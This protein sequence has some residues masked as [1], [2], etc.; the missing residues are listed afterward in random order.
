MSEHKAKLP[1]EAIRHAVAEALNE[2]VGEGDI[3]AALLPATM[4]ARAHVI[5]RQ[6][7]VLCGA[8]WFDEVYAQLDT[9][10]EV[11]WQARDGERVASDQLLC[12]L[13]GPARAILT[14]ER[15]ALNFLQLLSGTAT[16]AARFSA[17]VTGTGA[18]ILDTRKTLPGLRAAQ[19]YATRCGGC[20]NHRM[21][22][23]DG[24]LIKENH[25]AV[26]GGIAPAIVEA[27]RQR[28][29]LSIEV[30]VE[31]LTQLEEA[32]AAGA[33]IA[34]LDNFELEEL[35]EAVR[36]NA[37]RARLEASGGIGID[38]VREI[39]ETG[40]DRIS[41]GAITKDVQAVDLSMRFEPASDS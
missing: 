6:D 2:D 39:A 41:I 19:K 16:A 24:V 31:T 29:D 1:L 18:V 35:R 34:L 22:L 38:N 14:G 40:V 17:V 26:A 30:E 32:L 7:A 10:V 37:G 27:R 5:S 20:V 23:Y 12:T 36:I 4:R 3:T 15:T 11:R 21:G 28:A 8:P 13:H 25:I 9:G 33:D